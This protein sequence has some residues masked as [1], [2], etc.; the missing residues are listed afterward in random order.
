[1]T[2][3]RGQRTEDRDQPPSLKLRRAKEDRDQRSDIR[4]QMSGALRDHEDRELLPDGCFFQLVRRADFASKSAGFFFE[5]A[6]GELG[7]VVTVDKVSLN[8]MLEAAALFTLRDVHQ[9]VEEQLAI[10][11]G[12]GPN[13]NRVADGDTAAGRGDDL[14]ILRGRG[15]LCIVGERN[16]IDDQHFDTGGILHADAA[17]IGDLPRSQGNAARENEFFL[18][19]GPLTSKR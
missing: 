4:C 2:E 19:F 12:I 7:A 11:P 6:E 3:D 15:Q 13:D 17:R 1:M 10:T 8:P 9:L 18:S 16:S 14:G 5:T